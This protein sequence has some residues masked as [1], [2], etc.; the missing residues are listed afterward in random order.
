MMDLAW[1]Q[2]HKEE[3]KAGTRF[4]SRQLSR[5]KKNVG[6]EKGIED[7]PQKGTTERNGIVRRVV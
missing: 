4:I 6:A 1:Q 3:N 2:D 5:K 7:K